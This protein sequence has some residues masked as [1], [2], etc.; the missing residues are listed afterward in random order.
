MVL[1]GDVL[2]LDHVSPL[3]L[4]AQQSSPSLKPRKEIL[5]NYGRPTCRQIQ[6]PEKILFCEIP[7]RHIAEQTSYPDILYP[8]LPVPGNRLRVIGCAS[9]GCDGPVTVPAVSFLESEGK[10]RS[11]LRKRVVERL[12]GFAGSVALVPIDVAGSPREELLLSGFDL[13][14]HRLS[15]SLSCWNS[16]RERNVPFQSST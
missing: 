4:A 13:P 12:S 15:H 11:K 5:A 2:V 1:P 10:K 16:R 9:P 8:M 3:V 14:G 7:L 6:D